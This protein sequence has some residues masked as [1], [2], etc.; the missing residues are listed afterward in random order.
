MRRGDTLLVWTA[1]HCHVLRPQRSSDWPPRLQWLERACRLGTF[2]GKHELDLHS[3]CSVATCHSRIAHQADLA[4]SEL[5]SQWSL[6]DAADAV[7]SSDST[8]GIAVVDLKTGEL[9]SKSEHDNC[10]GQCH[11]SRPQCTSG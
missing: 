4:G 2:A 6:P 5:P 8:E 9:K 11:V 3:T 7:Q 1:V 10:G